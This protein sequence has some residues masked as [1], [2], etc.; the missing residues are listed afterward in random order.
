M[1][2]LQDFY[3][4][5]SLNGCNNKA[6]LYV[7]GFQLLKLKSANFSIQISIQISQ[8]NFWFEMTQWIQRK[9][10]NLESMAQFIAQPYLDMLL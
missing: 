9:V 3:W 4:L 8:M 2:L 6:T 5:T 7:N 1:T 10:A